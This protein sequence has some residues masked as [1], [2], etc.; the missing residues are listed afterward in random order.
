MTT[1]V[2]DLERRIRVL[3]D[4]EAIR[5]LKARYADACD[6]NYD[7]DAIASLFAEDAVWD[8]GTFGRYEGREAIRA[9][10]EGVSNDIPFAMHYMVNPIIEIDGEFAT[11]KW[12]LFQTC[13]FAA[14][15]QAIFGAARYDEEYRRIDGE[16]KFWRLTLTSSFWTPYEEGW[17]KRPFVQEG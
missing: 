6:R 16:W 9:F 8:G 10:F 15:N 11:G 2:E 5:R 14:G 12:H 17:V 13:T 1:N 7:A 3:E 4:I